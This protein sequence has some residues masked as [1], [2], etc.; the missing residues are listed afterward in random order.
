MVWSKRCAWCWLCC[1]IR[2]FSMAT[3]TKSLIRQVSYQTLVK[4]PLWILSITSC[5]FLVAFPAPLILILKFS[6]CELSNGARSNSQKIRELFHKLDFVI[7]WFR[8]AKIWFCL[9]V[10]AC[11]CQGFTWCQVL[12]ICGS[13]TQ[14]V[15]SGVK[16]KAEEYL[17]K[18]ACNTQLPCWDLS[19]WS[20]VART[21]NR[22]LC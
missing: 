11:S 16:L 12:M 10:E 20:M 8:M 2:R 22:R 15:S 5:T 4:V 6:T 19:S 14:I 13:L 1:G 9:V 17:Q 3:G 18:S 21:L 7:Q